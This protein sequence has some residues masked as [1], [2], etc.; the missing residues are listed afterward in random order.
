MVIVI[1]GALETSGEDT[2]EADSTLTTV[3]NTPPVATTSSTLVFVETSSA[4]TMEKE[5]TVGVSTS[6]VDITG[7]GRIN[8][9]LA[10]KTESMAEIVLFPPLL[11]PRE[12][13]SLF[14]IVNES[15]PPFVM[16]RSKGT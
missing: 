8:P 15:L 3:R 7:L 1:V 13:F 12:S 16:V 6:V 9:G 4:E 5:L 2:S 14:V 11:I 10:R